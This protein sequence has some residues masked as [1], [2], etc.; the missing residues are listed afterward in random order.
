MSPVCGHG[1]GAGYRTQGNCALV[2][3]LV[4]HYAHALDR[5]QNHS[6]LPYLIIQVP[7]AQ[8]LNKDII[9]ILQDTD[10]FPE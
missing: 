5:K 4:T 3:T 6:C 2:S 8:S 10:P 9:R 1:I 7:I